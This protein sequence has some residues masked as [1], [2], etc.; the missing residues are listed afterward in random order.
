MAMVEM[1]LRLLRDLPDWQVYRE[2]AAELEGDELLAWRRHYESHPERDALL[3]EAA[4]ALASEAR[5]RFP[6]L[7]DVLA[8]K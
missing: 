1:L 7:A 3:L 4:R 5:K 6:A 8:A 2:V